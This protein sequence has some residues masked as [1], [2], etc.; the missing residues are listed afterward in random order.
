MNHLAHIINHFDKFSNKRLFAVDTDQDGGTPEINS[1]KK[2]E[3][4]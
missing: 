2:Y 4:I 1:S 3:F